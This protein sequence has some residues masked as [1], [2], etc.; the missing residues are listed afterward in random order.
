M[1]ADREQ[2]LRQFQDLHQITFLNLDLLNLALCHSSYIS[3]GNGYVGNNEKLEFLGDSV[4]ALLVN[5]YLYRTFTEANEGELSRIKSILVS[6]YTL[7]EIGRKLNIGAY[8]LLGRGEELENGTTRDHLIADAVEALLGAIFLDQGL[9]IVKSFFAPFIEFET[10]RII[11]NEHRPD[12][13]S[14]LQLVIQQKYK[15]CPSYKTVREEG[16]DHSKQFFVRVQIK[17][18]SFG[19]GEG[20]SKKEAQ[21]DAARLA[22][23][24]LG[25]L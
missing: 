19:V 2:Q 25:I 22:L 12:Y 6:S 23:K 15:A 9:T 21:Q 18:R 20:C 11:N 13:K 4:L 5:E 10:E 3:S 16:P 24:E 14:N 8:L 7:A 1:N 17:G